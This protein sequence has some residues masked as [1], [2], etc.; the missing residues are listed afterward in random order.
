M[1]AQTQ[2][3]FIRSIDIHQ[4]EMT[5]MEKQLTAMEK[6]LTAMEKDFDRSTFVD[7]SDS[8]SE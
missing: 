2:N 1:V 3:D 7:E 8:D 6:Q 4:T 5:Q